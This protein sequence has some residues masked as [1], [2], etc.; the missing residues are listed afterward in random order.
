MANE[1]DNKS[2]LYICSGG[3]SKEQVTGVFKDLFRQ[4]ARL[5]PNDQD[6]VN[7]NFMINVVETKSR[8]DP[9]VSY[10]NGVTY[11]WVSH[12]K[13]YNLLTG[14][15]LD[16]S[17]LCRYVRKEDDDESV[18]TGADGTKRSW[19]EISEEEEM[20]KEPLAPLLEIKPI[21]LTDEQVRIRAQ[22]TGSEIENVTREIKLSIT[23]AYVVL[24]DQS[25]DSS[26]LCCRNA[27]SWVTEKMMHEIFDRFNTDTSYH[28]VVIDKR[29]LT[30]QH[31]QIRIRAS[32]NG[33]D[34]NMIYISYSKVDRHRADAS[35]ALQMCRRLRLRESSVSGSGG[36]EETLTFSYW[37]NG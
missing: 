19:A 35:F 5:Y 9:S 10:A 32:P 24:P 31:P 11:A 33:R 17:E 8:I 27:P 23:A 15:A 28:R 29:T 13:V 37:K 30:I 4:M 3:A 20:V 2:N 21:V 16:G 26:T 25:Y 7:A 6:I 14:L 22:N 12:A 34:G 36:R 18:I 1:F